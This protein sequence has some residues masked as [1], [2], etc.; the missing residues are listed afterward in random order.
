MVDTPTY[1][2]LLRV[3]YNWIEFLIAILIVS[4]LSFFLTYLIFLNFFV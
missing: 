1:F 2:Y 3:Y 4:A